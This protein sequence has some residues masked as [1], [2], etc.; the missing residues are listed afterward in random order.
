MQSGVDQTTREQRKTQTGDAA[1]E[2][3][4][5]PDSKSTPIRS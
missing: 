5:H 3:T 4:Y 1:K 2:Q